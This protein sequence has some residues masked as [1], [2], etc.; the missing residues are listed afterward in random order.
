MRETL[1]VSGN[2][3]A[4]KRITPAYAG[5]T[6]IFFATPVLF[7]GSPPRMRETLGQGNLKQRSSGITPAYA[8]NTVKIPLYYAT[9]KFKFHNFHLVF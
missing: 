1:N 2:L 3:K 7:L 8:G 6:S 9:P 4:A 5:N